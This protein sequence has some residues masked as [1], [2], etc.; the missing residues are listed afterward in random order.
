M[1]KLLPL[2]AFVSLIAGGCLQ[3]EPDAKKVVLPAAGIEIKKQL[4]GLETT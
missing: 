3:N 1:R 4:L 2:L